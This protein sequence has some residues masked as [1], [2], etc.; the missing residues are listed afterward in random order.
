MR[1]TVSVTVCGQRRPVSS[2]RSL[3]QVSPGRRE[4]SDP[5]QTSS[6]KRTSQ[7]QDR[8]LTRTEGWLKRRQQQRWTEATSAAMVDRS[9]VISKGGLKQLHQQRWTEATSSAKRDRS[10]VISKGELK[11]RHQQRWTEAT[12][13]AKRD[14]S[15]VI[16]KGE[17]TCKQIRNSTP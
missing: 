6:A 4:D 3:R 11:Q 12:S 8:H 17:L 2:T 10:N 7:C 14:R 5:Q 16:S 1:V 9:N 13:S 15:N